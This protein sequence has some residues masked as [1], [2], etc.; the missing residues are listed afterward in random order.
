MRDVVDR[1]ISDF[2]HSS[3]LYLIVKL[4]QVRL[5]VESSVV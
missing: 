2:E 5:K 3:P 4:R 1:F